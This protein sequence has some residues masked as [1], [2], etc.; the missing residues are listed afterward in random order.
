MPGKF[1][2][3]GLWASIPDFLARLDDF[4]EQI[5]RL[6]SDLL[7]EYPE[8]YESG[9]AVVS[10]D[11]ERFVELR[12]ELEE[13]MKR[14]L[15]YQRRSGQVQD[16]DQLLQCFY[17]ISDFCQ[18]VTMEGEEFVHTLSAENGATRLKIVC[19]DPARQ[20]R[21]VNERYRSVIAMSATLSPMEFYR[22]VLGFDRQTELLA[23]PSPFPRENRRIL[24]VPELPPPISS[25][26]NTFPG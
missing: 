16:E 23:L 25:A 18:V 9:N 8:A 20:L 24:I 12:S 13:L 4:L 26:P 22:D 6:F 2:C 1:V 11:R 15:I 7:A 17:A 10:L 3:P 21:R 19:V 14:Y 5:Q